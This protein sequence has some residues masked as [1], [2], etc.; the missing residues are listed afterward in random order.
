VCYP[1]RETKRLAGHSRR[2]MECVLA[3]TETHQ[4]PRPGNSVAR[5]AT[6]MVSMRAISRFIGIFSSAF[7]ARLLTP[8]DFGLV[9]LGTSVLGI[10]QMLSELSLANALIRMRETAAA[11]YH[12]AWT[13][14]LIRSGLVAIVVV[15]AAPFVGDSMH[16]PRVV[17][18]LLTL[19]AATII[20][21]FE[22][23][24]LVDFQINM[25]FSGVFRYQ[26]VARLA[27]IPATLILA[28]ILRS[29]WALVISTL[30][31]SVATVCYSY[32]L[33]P[34]RP[35][36]SL[37]A[38]RDL[39]DFSKWAVLGTYLAIIDNY[40]ITFL[41]GW[42][43]GARQL[44]MYQVSQQIAALPASEI[45]APIRPPLYAAFA[46]LLDNPSELAR[47]FT[48]GF[49]F[50]FLVITPMS[51]GIF[52]AAPMIAPL[53]LGPQ[54]SDAPAMIEAVVFYA[55]G[56]YPQNLFVVMNRQPRLLALA[57]VFLADRVPAAIY[58]GWVGGATGAVYGMVASALFGSVFWFAASLPLVKV[59][60]RAV[61]Q[62]IW[63]STVAGAIMVFTLLGLRTLWP[64][65]HAYGP[66]AIQLLSFAALGSLLH[67]GVLL[68]LW[69]WSGAPPGAEER[70]IGIVTR[71]WRRTIWMRPGVLRRS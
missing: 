33:A 58:G 29:Y 26:L 37:S 55:F 63:R 48:E 50:L 8:D 39:F 10:V 47:T 40:S 69:Q 19:A 12:T 2:D 21:S 52:V 20:G 61:I 64:A 22:S 66:L 3:E 38:W 51:L 24:R 41:L 35:R 4:S 30:I 7:L 57:S 42:L 54:W 59:R 45:A 5:G 15:L 17:P 11:H 62:A 31:T 23:I 18:I 14:G 44:G 36:L 13:L 32:V 9:V 53:A 49:G 46:R 16:E 68:L 28:V 65:E 6:L 56:H 67:I 71:L 1:A 27:S 25:N 43:G 34:Y 60:P 70:A